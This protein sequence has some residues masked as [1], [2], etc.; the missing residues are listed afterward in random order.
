MER[1]REA[2]ADGRFE[3]WAQPILDVRRGRPAGQELLLRL[4][5]ADGSIIEP[6]GFI[7]S[8]ERLG[9][10][11]EIDRFVIEHAVAWLSGHEHPERLNVNISAITLADESILDHIRDVVRT[12]GVDPTRLV[13]EL[14]ETAAITNMAA[15]RRLI[16][17]LSDAGCGSALDDF[18]NGFVSF[19]YLRELP[20]DYVKIDGSFIEH[21]C[22][23]NDD[24]AVFRAIVDVAHGLGKKAIAEKVQLPTVL[25]ILRS[26]GVDYAQGFTIGLPAPLSSAG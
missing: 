6:A 4:R 16:E 19:T 20:V 7:P 21:L 13:F 3:I 5:E 22:S 15:A 12:S 25:E 14:T 10:I 9:M 18:G 1:L 2:L 17:G 24:R 11:G 26:M 8:A 23:R